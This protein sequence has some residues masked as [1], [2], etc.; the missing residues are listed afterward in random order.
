MSSV[1][2]PALP[3]RHLGSTEPRLDKM[4]ESPS[5]DRPWMASKDSSVRVFSPYFADMQRTESQ[6]QIAAPA[7]THRPG[8]K[9]QHWGADNVGSTPRTARASTVA[10]PRSP[11]GDGPT[12]ARPR[13]QNRGSAAAVEPIQIPQRVSA[14][15][16]S[17]SPS[18]LNVESLLA[19]AKSGN[20]IRMMQGQGG[21]KTQR[22]LAKVQDYQTLALACKRAGKQREEGQAYLAL[23]AIY[24]NSANFLKA[25]SF[26][27]KFFAISNELKDNVNACAALN[28]IG[29]CHQ[30]IGG[31]RHLDLAIE[32]H[33]KHLERADV[34]GKFIAHC[35]LGLAFSGKGEEEKATLNHRQALRYAILLADVAG[36]ALACG[37]L[38]MS[39]SRKGDDV[40]ARACLERHLKLS[41]TLDDKRGSADA[42]R[43]L[44][45]MSLK[46]GEYDEASRYFESALVLAQEMEE[47]KKEVELKCQIGVARG[48]VRLDEMKAQLQAIVESEMNE[49]AGM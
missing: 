7:S 3:L 4:R 30:M 49:E 19:Q 36:E 34:N 28:S 1:E 5:F 15:V 37:N 6:T 39:G 35:N 17:G 31:E 47:E 27:E 22:E 29:V 41:D 46:K 16:E 18:R 12:S 40:T 32:H 45:F 21:S 11:P 33:A 23:G 24:E 26:Y 10:T 13:L 14:A 25:I 48:T 2:L 44:G 8:R 9:Q 42:C 38:G 43:E 20:P